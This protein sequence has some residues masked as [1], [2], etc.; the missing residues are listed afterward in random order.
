MVNVKESLKQISVMILAFGAIFICTVFVNYSI[1]L[2]SVE[3]FIDTPQAQA[4]YDAL[5]TQNKITVAAA[6]GMLG[7]VTLLVLLFSIAQ[8]INESSAELGVMKAL[9][10]SENRIALEFS[11]FGM[12]FLRRERLRILPP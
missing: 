2:K 12:G 7:A 8:F 11:K 5:T 6:G 9:G 10:Y 3:P 4:V 1:D